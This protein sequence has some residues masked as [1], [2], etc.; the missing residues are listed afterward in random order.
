MLHHLIVNYTKECTFQ[1]ICFS[2]LIYI[3]IG[4]DISFS[5]SIIMNNGK[6]FNVSFVR[7]IYMENA[8]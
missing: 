7:E 3:Q 2:I 5:A 4:R 8:L 1:E 6:V